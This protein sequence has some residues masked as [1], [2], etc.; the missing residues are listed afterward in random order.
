MFSA[1][2]PKR[3]SIAC[4]LS[5]SSMGAPAWLKHQTF[6]DVDPHDV[7]LQKALFD[8]YAVTWASPPS[9]RWVPGARP[10]STRSCCRAGPMVL[11]WTV[12]AVV[13]AWVIRRGC[14]GSQVSL[15]GG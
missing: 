11:S 2:L 1:S 3:L 5:E 7:T 13:T 15:I 6:A 14:P 8:P 9:S 4:V 12:A 10:R